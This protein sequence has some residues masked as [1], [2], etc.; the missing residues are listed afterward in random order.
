[1]SARDI[2]ARIAAE[3][4]WTLQTQ[5]EVVMN[6]VE[7]LFA[8]DVFLDFLEQAVEE[9]NAHTNENIHRLAVEAVW[10]FEH[11]FF[12]YDEEAKHGDYEVMCPHCGEDTPISGEYC[13]HC[14][15]HFPEGLSKNQI[16]FDNAVA[17]VEQAIRKALMACGHWGTDTPTDRAIC[18]DCGASIPPDGHCWYCENNPTQMHIISDRRGEGS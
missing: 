18:P 16:V 15:A 4:G 13:R 11:H 14:G 5:L 8:N 10:H 9:E 7:A 17:Q 12:D 2:L 6:Y 3:Q 1:M